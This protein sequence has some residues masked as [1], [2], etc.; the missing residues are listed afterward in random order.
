E[1]N[2]LDF[3]HRVLKPWAN[4]PAFYVTVFPDRSDQP[5]R[6]GPLAAGAVEL[7]TYAFP[8]TPDRAEAMRPGIAAIPKLLEQAKR[9]LTGN[10]RDLWV[11][12]AKSIRRQSADLAAL[13]SRVGD[14]AGAL[15]ADIQRAREATDGFASWLDAQ[16]P[17]KTGASGVGFDN[18]NWYLRNVQLVP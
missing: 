7:W 4:N 16:I 5:A 14:A 10:G 3:D 18:Y 12:G 1:M 2:G 9:N 6:E 17:S 11:Y 8:L 13:A 15:K